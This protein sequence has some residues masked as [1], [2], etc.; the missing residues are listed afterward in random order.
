ASTSNWSKT[1]SSAA[2]TSSLARLRL[3]GAS[4]VSNSSDGGSLY[5]GSLRASCSARVGGGVCAGGAGGLRGATGLRGAAT[6]SGSTSV[7]TVDDEPT[8]LDCRRREGLRR[9]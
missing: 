3:F 6:V 9:R 4:P 7:S 8:R 5:V 1:P 2:I